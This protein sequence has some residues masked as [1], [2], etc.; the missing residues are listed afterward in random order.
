MTVDWVHITIIYN[1]H[2]KANAGNNGDVVTANKDN[3]SGL[4]DKQW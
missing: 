1:T 3:R 2:E 4:Q